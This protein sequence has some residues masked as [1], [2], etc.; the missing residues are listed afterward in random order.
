MLLALRAC[1]CLKCFPPSEKIISEEVI[2]PQKNYFQEKLSSRSEGIL[3]KFYYTSEQ[4]K[5]NSRTGILL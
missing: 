2:I 4:A 1:I 5:K 3:R